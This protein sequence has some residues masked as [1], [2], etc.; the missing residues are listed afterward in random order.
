VSTPPFQSVRATLKQLPK[1]KNTQELS[2][3][4]ETFPAGSASSHLFPSGG[5]SS[6]Q[7]EKRHVP[8]R[9]P[10]YVRTLRNILEKGVSLPVPVTHPYLDRR[11]ASTQHVVRSLPIWCSGFSRYLPRSAPF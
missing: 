11:R 6:W 5:L 8:G 9:L 2:T 10:V 4:A 7:R 3:L 1:S